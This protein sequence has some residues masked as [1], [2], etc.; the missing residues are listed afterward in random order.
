MDEKV[1][2][3]AE[4]SFDSLWDA[5]GAPIDVFDD[6]FILVDLRDDGAEE[7]CP[8]DVLWGSLKISE[9]KGR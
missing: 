9:G 7:R 6:V 8:L 5:F 2:E 3:A 1:W 4:K